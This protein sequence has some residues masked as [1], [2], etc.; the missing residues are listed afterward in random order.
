MTLPHENQKVWRVAWYWAHGS[1]PQDFMFCETKFY[2]C[3]ED[4]NY[5][6]VCHRE[7]KS[8]R[9]WRVYV[10]ELLSANSGSKWINVHEEDQAGD[11]ALLTM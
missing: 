9:A 8:L 10:D 7:E 5:S 3:L 4:W 6:L 11:P 1:E 2:T